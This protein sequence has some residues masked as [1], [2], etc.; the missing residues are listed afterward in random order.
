MKTIYLVIEQ[1][2]GYIHKAFIS[3]YKAEQHVK[4]LEQETGF[5]CF[6]VQNLDLCEYLPT[7]EELEKAGRFPTLY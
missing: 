1:G 2:A 4:Q 5:E 6:E 7:I 3:E